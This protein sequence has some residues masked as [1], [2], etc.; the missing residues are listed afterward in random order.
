MTAIKIKEMFIDLTAKD[1]DL[2]FKQFYLECLIGQHKECELKL[3]RLLK[4]RSKNYY[5]YEREVA[6]PIWEAIQ[7][8]EKEIEEMKINLEFN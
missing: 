5:K 8:T 6:D 3:I 2:K 1:K 7:R 4:R